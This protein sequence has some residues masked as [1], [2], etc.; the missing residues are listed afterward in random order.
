VFILCAVGILMSVFGHRRGGKRTKIL[1]AFAAGSLCGAL[2]MLL[3]DTAANT[4]R[5]DTIK[6]WAVLLVGVVAALVVALFLSVS[7]SLT[8]VVGLS[9]I[10][11]GFHSLALPIAALISFLLAGAA[12]LPGASAELRTVGLGVAGLLV[13]AVLVFLGDRVLRVRRMRVHRRH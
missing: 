8:A 13:G 12:W 7:E 4:I 9:M 2:W 1:V 10:V 11:I 6:G 3:V 5:P